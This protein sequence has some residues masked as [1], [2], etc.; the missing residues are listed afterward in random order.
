MAIK[1]DQFRPARC[2]RPT[3]ERIIVRKDPGAMKD[4]PLKS[5]IQQLL[6]FLA[7][8]VAAVGHFEGL[9]R[10]DVPQAHE[11]RDE[12]NEEHEA[13]DKSSENGG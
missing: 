10:L 12:D 9:R 6:H 4:L 11:A 3:A 7:G 1:R 13:N 2:P 5:N 8:V